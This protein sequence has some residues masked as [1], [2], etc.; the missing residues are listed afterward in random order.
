MPGNPAIPRQAA[1][2]LLLRTVRPQ[3][4]VFMLARH[5]E[6]D[7]A[8][9]ALVFPGG[10]VDAA[11]GDPALAPFVS[12]AESLEDTGRALR[13][14]AIRE[15]FEECG[16][17]LARERGAQA[18]VPPARLNTLEAYRQPLTRGETTM[19][20]LV[21]R[22]K[23]DLAADLLVAYSHWVTPVFMPKRFDTWFF[24]AHAPED[25]LA[26]H[27]GCESVDSV[28][29][30]PSAA[31]ADLEA[32]RRVILF[33]TRLNLMMLDEART[34]D[35]AIA[36]ARLRPIRTVE[37][38]IAERD[39]KQWLTIRADAGYALTEIPVDPNRRR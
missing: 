36:A 8:S 13:V 4:Q 28:W 2:V 35:E 6:I 15:A 29:I 26:I 11:D 12:G 37:P 9:G 14:A 38:W 16:V 39:G 30:S 1:T 21:T 23:L 19:L 7:F 25:Q 17:L 34:A 10:K 3:M 32:K 31:L 20:E 22:E 18:S 27:D 24:L 5:E 33:P